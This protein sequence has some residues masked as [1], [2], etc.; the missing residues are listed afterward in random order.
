M[1]ENEP[2]IDELDDS[3]KDKL[4]AI[5]KGVVGL[6]PMVGG[7]LAEI[8]GMVVPGQ[9][10]DRIAAY[11]RGL[12]VRVDGLEEELRRG[13]V[14][15]VEK[16]DLIEEGGYQAA[17]ATSGKRID[18]IIEAVA[19]GLSE[20]D[21]D[22]IR[23]KRL[24]LIF[25]ELDDDEV[26]LLNAYG[27]SYAGADRKAFEHVNR[28]GPVHFQSSTMEIDRERLFQVGKEHLLRLGLLK[29]NYGSVRKGQMPEFD[30]S[31]GDFKHSVGISHLGRMLLKEIGMITPFDEQQAH[32]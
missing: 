3:W 20:D 5:S 31:Q 21:A 18:Q 16:I 13:V 25:G 15:N 19:R 2:K 6:V 23:R 32:R 11:L 22:V 29:K 24:L 17:R 4:V 8:V 27:R 1:G 7:P 10:A 14:T 30:A 28:P 12:A 26:I 9:R